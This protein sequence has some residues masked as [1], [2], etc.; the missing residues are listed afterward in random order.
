MVR[1][2]GVSRAA[3]RM[4]RSSGSKRGVVNDTVAKWMDVE[5][6]GVRSNASH[7]SVAYV[8]VYANARLRQAVNSLGY[9]EGTVHR[10]FLV[11]F[12]I[13]RANHQRSRSEVK[14]IIKDLSQELT[15]PS[16]ACTTEECSCSTQQ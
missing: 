3:V 7:R 13:A 5:Q 2:E 14:N 1:D 10:A 12:E 4:S 16:T 15:N 8:D 6:M 9:M 11:G